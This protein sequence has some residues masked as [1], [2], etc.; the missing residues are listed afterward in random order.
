MTLPD[1]E[2]VA[3]LEAQ[4]GEISRKLD[5]ILTQTER[6]NGRVGRLERWR[7]WITG[8]LA[9]MGLLWTLGAWMVSSGAL[10]IMET[11]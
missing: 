9:G 4:F 5:A 6:T 1:G 8:G 11:P 3:T 10:K 7:S 2:R